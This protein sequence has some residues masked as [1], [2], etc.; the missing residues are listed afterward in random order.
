MPTDIKV[1]QSGDEKILLNSAADIFDN[2]VNPDLA[3]E[4]LADS[5]HHIVV[6]ID[7]GQ[8][9][10]FASAIHYIHPDKPPELWINEVALAPAH[11]RQG[12]GKAVLSALLDVGKKL[13]CSNAWVL[14]YQNNP[15]AKALYES[16]GGTQGADNSGAP[17]QMLGYQ[18]ALTH[19]S[20]SEP[21]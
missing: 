8:V 7:D 3:K 18:F 11:R 17:N 5:R 10:G 12:L 16:L 4:F 9:V 14:T 20:Q 15:A 21:Q 6:A 19:K 1:L 13:N 2:P